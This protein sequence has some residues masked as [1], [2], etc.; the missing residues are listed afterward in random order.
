MITFVYMANAGSAVSAEFLSAIHMPFYVA[1]NSQAESNA[2]GLVI[3]DSFVNPEISCKICTAVELLDSVEQASV[4][5]TANATNLT[6]ATKFAFLAMDECGDE[7][8]MFKVAAKA[9]DNAI[10]YSNTTSVTLHGN[11]KR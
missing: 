7:N 6:G 3:R 2:T 1:E 4:A 5:Y 9:Q 11:W 10:A 8:V